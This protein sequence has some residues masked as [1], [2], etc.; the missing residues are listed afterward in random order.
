M[1]QMVTTCKPSA[2][3]QQAHLNYGASFYVASTNWLS[4]CLNQP[5]SQSWK[6][7]RD[8]IINHYITYTQ[9]SICNISTPCAQMWSH[10]TGLWWMKVLPFLQSCNCSKLTCQV[11]LW[12]FRGRLITASTRALKSQLASLRHQ[13]VNNYQRKIRTIVQYC[14]SCLHTVWTVAIT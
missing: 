12:D 1:R 5:W 6:F 11:D 9:N 13:V 2:F 10:S 3:W 4:W 7:T 8:S 14:Y